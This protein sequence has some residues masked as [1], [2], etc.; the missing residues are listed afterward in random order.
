MLFKNVTSIV[1]IILKL[2]LHIKL[3]LTNLYVVSQIRCKEGRAG[4][5]GRGHVGAH[6]TRH[7]KSH[8]SRYTL[9]CG[10]IFIAYFYIVFTAFRNHINFILS[11]CLVTIGVSVDLLRKIYKKYW[12]AANYG[13]Y[14]L[15]GIYFWY[16]MK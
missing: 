14:F 1:L 9:H 16:G 15:Y 5:T 7:V 10:C 2:Y 4:R 3:R 6:D 12:N 8:V 11:Y 13:S